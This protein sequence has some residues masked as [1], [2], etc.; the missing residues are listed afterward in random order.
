MS[1][2]RSSSR[3]RSR[4]RST[5]ILTS[6]ETIIESQVNQIVQKLGTLEQSVNRYDEV[7]EA[8]NAVGRSIRKLWMKNNPKRNPKRGDSNFGPAALVAVYN[9]YT[10]LTNYMQNGKDMDDDEITETIEGLNDCAKIIDSNQGI[11]SEVLWDTTFG[12][13][14]PA[15][16]IK[17]LDKF[18]G[19]KNPIAKWILKQL[20][21]GAKSKFSLVGLLSYNIY[22]S[23]WY[24][25]HS[26]DEMQRLGFD[27]N[28]S[29]AFR[30][31]AQIS[32]LEN[33]FKIP[34]TIVSGFDAASRSWMTVAYQLPVNAI[35][36]LPESVQSLLTMLTAMLMYSKQNE[37]KT[38]YSFVF[39]YLHDLTSSLFDFSKYIADLSQNFRESSVM[40]FQENL[41]M[42]EDLTGFG[43]DFQAGATISK[44]YFDSARANYTAMITTIYLIPL[45]FTILFL[46][47]GSWKLCCRGSSKR[48]GREIIGSVSDI[49]RSREEENFKEI[50][51]AGQRIA[52]PS[53][54]EWN[55]R[56][57][58]SSKTRSKTPKTRVKKSMRRP[59]K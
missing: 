4:R 42:V 33:I 43:A 55:F 52:D 19:L 29:I 28:K 2:A 36:Y 6:P 47:I 41:P 11:V 21:H 26:W 46:T 44:S 13:I 16:Y 30:T 3:S 48:Q 32:N 56:T 31:G 54:Y 18:F 53:T 59:K 34:K 24:F 39:Q 22:S 15:S 37:E 27:M 12:T 38:W 8:R 58:R 57:K 9:T 7:Y 49:L 25:C 40:M 20:N 45:L 50:M 17:R 5:P 23:Y 51:K 35:A 10:L 14:Y 1:S